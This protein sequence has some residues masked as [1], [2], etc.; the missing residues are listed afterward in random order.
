MPNI[1]LSEARVKTLPPRSRLV[2]PSTTSAAERVGAAMAR[3]MALE[4]PL[5]A[6]CTVGCGGCR[7]SRRSQWELTRKGDIAVGEPIA[8]DARQCFGAGI[9][10]SP[11]SRDVRKCSRSRIL[12]HGPV[13]VAADVIIG[14]AQPRKCSMVWETVN[15]TE[16]KRLGGFREWD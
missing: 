14:L 16:S 3:T 2:R 9:G 12:S 15:S 13:T 10:I 8:D 1:A 5:P 6:R 4:S 11:G 7:I